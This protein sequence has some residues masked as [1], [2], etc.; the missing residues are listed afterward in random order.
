M[1][2]VFLRACCAEIPTAYTSPY[3]VCRGVIL[4]P[5]KDV[6]Q[7]RFFGTYC[8]VRDGYRAKILK[9][10][11]WTDCKSLWSAKMYRTNKPS[12]ST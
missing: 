2:I 9:R 1:D 6:V 7:C 11:K 3:R 4:G 12:L 5:I 10:L 8:L